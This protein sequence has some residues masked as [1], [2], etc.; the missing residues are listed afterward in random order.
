MS[1]LNY[2]IPLLPAYDI[3]HEGD[4][5]LT[6]R[7]GNV[8]EKTRF[9]RNAVRQRKK[10]WPN[11]VIPY[12]IEEGLGR[13][14]WAYINALLLSKNNRHIVWYSAK[15]PYSPVNWVVTQRS[16]ER[17]SVAWRLRIKPWP[18]GVASQRKL[19]NVNLRTQTCDGWPNGLARRRK[20]NTSSKKAISVQPCTCARTKENNTET[21]L[22]R[23][24][25]GGQ[26]VKT[27]VHFRA[28]L[29]SIK[30]NASHRKP[31]QVHAS[32]G[33]TVS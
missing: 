22:R 33:Q 26:T 2:W 10:V 3:G 7:D 8:Y 1:K 18:N 28:N 12:E 20:F 17:T 15:S 16:S 11:R 6:E 30:V 19:G 31:S 27:C 5:A 21:N 24:S 29:S 32:H 23:L 4:I 9:R 13:F 25:L 14:Y